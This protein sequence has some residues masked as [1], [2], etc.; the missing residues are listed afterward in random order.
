[1]QLK[2][3]NKW[4]SLGGS[5]YI[6]DMQDN[7]IFKVKGKVFTFTS[8]KFFMDMNDNVLFIIRNKFWRLFTRRAFIM[9]KDNNIIC[10]VSKKFFSIRSK[11]FV[12]G[13]KD[14]IVID[15]NIL[16]FNFRIMKNGVEVGHLAR[17]ISLRDSFELTINDDN[18][19]AFICA[20]VIAIDNILDRRDAEN[21]SNY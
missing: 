6:T 5:S 13:Y 17:K 18:D 1:M 7:Q 16:D 12:E 11:F 15:G 4:I 21:S 19:A 14:E 3:K 8:K 2:I 9:D 10:R 20:L